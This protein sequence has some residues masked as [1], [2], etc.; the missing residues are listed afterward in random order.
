MKKFNTLIIGCGNIGGKF[1]SSKQGIQRPLTHAGAYRNHGGFDLLACV[2]V[3]SDQAQTFQREWG[4]KES[5]LPTELSSLGKG[6]FDVISICSPTRFHEEHL[7]AAAKL[8]PKLVFC[9]KPLTETSLK[10]NEI[11]NLYEAIGIVLAVNYTRRWDPVVIK[12][13]EDISSGVWGEVRSVIG[14]YS[15]GILNNGS[16]LID[17]LIFLFGTISVV[18]AGKRTYDY[19]PEDP[20]ISGL[21]QTS[22]GIP[23]HLVG[24]D[25]RDYANFELQIM[26][27]EGIITMENGGLKWR[28]RKPQDSDRFIGYKTLDKALEFEGSYDL[29]M[30][31]A[32]DNIYQAII[33]GDALNSSGQ[34]A[35]Q[36]QYLCEML[37]K[38]SE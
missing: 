10:S 7:L 22:L 11:N 12:M 19:S 9:E 30:V 21:L 28:I 38:T 32:V 2:D 24:G 26:T 15:K 20:T 34:T 14:I 8:Q 25:A 16:H 17:L 27:S 13:G 4:I 1:D 5:Y 36:A 35:M 29:A 33:N 6:A 23:I 3:D 37:F 31:G 18:Y